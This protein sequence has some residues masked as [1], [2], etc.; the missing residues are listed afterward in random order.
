MKEKV[1]TEEKV[2]GR[3]EIEKTEETPWPGQCPNRRSDSTT[4]VE[5]S[6]KKR[7]EEVEEN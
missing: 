2:D 3:P 1:E 6:K 5:G 7:G 4:R